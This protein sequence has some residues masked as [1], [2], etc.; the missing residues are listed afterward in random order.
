VRVRVCVC[1][2]V[3]LIDFDRG[4][5]LANKPIARVESNGTGENEERKGHDGGVAKVQQ[6]RDE[7]GDFE[8]GVKVNNR[9]AKHVK[10][11]G[12]RCKIR[13]PPPMIVLLSFRMPNTNRESVNAR[14]ID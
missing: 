3:D 10:R 1:F 8:S 4:V 7:F 5:D 13:A 9:I 14:L 6:D 11:R 12:T 2:C